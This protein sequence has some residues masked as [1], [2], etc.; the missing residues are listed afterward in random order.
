MVSART[1]VR[2]VAPV[3]VAFVAIPV[4]GQFFISLADEWGLYKNP[5]AKVAAMTAW[6]STVTANAWFHWVGGAVIGFAAGVWLDAFLKGGEKRQTWPGWK[7]NQRPAQVVGRTFRNERILVDGKN[8]V[9]CKFYNV[10]FQYN[11]KG[12]V[13]FNGCYF[14][15]V[16]VDTEDMPVAT[17]FMLLQGTGFIREGI[18]INLPPGAIF[19]RPKPE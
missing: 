14:S 8:F 15:G 2:L 12:P 10:T 16:Y 3:L 13:G 19:E 9:D 17:T 11:G 1:I 5:S 7:V 18:D 4:A 6:L